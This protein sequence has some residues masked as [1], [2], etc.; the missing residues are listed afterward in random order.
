MAFKKAFIERVMSAELRGLRGRSIPPDSAHWARVSA[1][2]SGLLS[3][4]IDGGA[5][6]RS[7]S[8]FNVRATLAAGEFVPTSMCGPPR[9][10]RG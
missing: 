4:R 9:V 5:P 1:M 6:R 8:S 7:T 10:T 3:I 2:N